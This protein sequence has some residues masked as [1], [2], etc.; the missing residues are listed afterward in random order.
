MTCNTFHVHK[1]AAGLNPFTSL[2][3][4]LYLSH[5]EIPYHFLTMIQYPFMSSWF[6]NKFLALPEMFPSPFLSPGLLCFCIFCETVIRN[7]I[8]PKIPINPCP[9]SRLDFLPLCILVLISFIHFLY[10][11]LIS[12]RS[13]SLQSFYKLFENRKYIIYYCYLSFLELEI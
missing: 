8:S 11:M 4:I 3:N 10:S 13:P 7:D 12:V 1:L 5:S 6:Y 9:E 2:P